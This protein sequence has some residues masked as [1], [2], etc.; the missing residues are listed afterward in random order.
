GTFMLAPDER[1]RSTR[2]L[3]RF[4]DDLTASVE[5]RT[6]AALYLMRTKPWDLF[7]VVYWDTDM[8]QHETWRLLDPGHPRHDSEE[9][10]ASR[11]RILEFY[12][13]VDADVGRLLAEVDSD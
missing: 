3:N 6:Q 13:K 10:A 2:W 1:H 7:T 11:A 8:V 9:A 4:L 5:N 12:R